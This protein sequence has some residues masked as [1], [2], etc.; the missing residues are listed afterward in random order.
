VLL[1]SMVHDAREPLDLAALIDP[2]IE[3]EP[4]FVLGKR[5]MGPGLTGAEV[6]AAVD[7]VSVCFEV[8]DSRIIDWRIRIEDTVADNGSS[9]RVVLGAEKVKPSRLALENLDAVMEL[10]GV[11]VERGNTGAILGHPATSAA[12]LA[13]TLGKFGVALEPGFIVLPGTCMR[14][15]R[16]AGHRRATGRIA[17]LGEVTLITQNAPSVTHVRPS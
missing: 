2:Q 10:D 1:D 6:L 4:A 11:A 16:I 9:A 15:R 8:I 7:F 17:G 5:L 3:V 13:N 14:S 12:W